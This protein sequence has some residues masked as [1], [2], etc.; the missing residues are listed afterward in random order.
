MNGENALSIVVILI[1]AVFFGIVFLISL[2]PSVINAIG[3]ARICNKLGAFRP[4]WSWVWALLVPA[5]AVLRAGDTA[6]LRD[7]FGKRKMFTHG[8]V[9]IAVFTVFTTLAVTCMG[10]YAAFSETAENIWTIVAFIAM[11]VFTLLAVLAAIWMVIPLY[12]SYFRIFKAY[13]PAWGAWLT[14]LGMLVFSQFAFLVMPVLS[15]LPL[16]EVEQNQ[17]SQF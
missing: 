15:F 7:S 9:A 2:L 14:L 11:M 17:E 10:A 1:Y 8:I 6:A 16:R 13:M 5:V 12:I 3:L 4:V